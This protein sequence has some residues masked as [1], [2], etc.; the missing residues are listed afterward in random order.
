[1][2]EWRRL[3]NVFGED[4]E[5]QNF[6]TS[7]L[8]DATQRKAVHLQDQPSVGEGLRVDRGCGAGAGG[9]RARSSDPSLTWPTGATYPRRDPGRGGSR[10]GRG[11][12][13]GAGCADGAISRDRHAASRSAHRIRADRAQRAHRRAGRSFRPPLTRRRPFRILSSG[14]RAGAGPAG[15]ECRPPQATQPHRAWPRHRCRDRSLLLLVHLAGFLG[16]A[17]TDV[18]GLG[19]DLA[20][21]AGASGPEAPATTALPLAASARCQ[22]ASQSWKR[23]AP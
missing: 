9:D 12:I 22:R 10:D 11:R 23:S 20:A 7:V 17:R 1:M 18:I 21:Q 8:S 4:L 6:L 2:R 15:T 5:S 16:E 19:L 3:S 13:G 14:P